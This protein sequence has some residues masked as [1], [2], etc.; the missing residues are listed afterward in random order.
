LYLLIID[1]QIVFLWLLTIVYV[2]YGELF[3]S[4]P[5]SSLGPFVGSTGCAH[6]DP[7]GR[8]R[9]IDQSET[10]GQ[11]RLGGENLGISWPKIARKTWQKTRDSRQQ[12]SVGKN[13]EH[14]N[15][16]EHVQNDSLAAKIWGNGLQGWEHTTYRLNYSTVDNHSYRVSTLVAGGLSEISFSYASFILDEAFWLHGCNAMGIGGWTTSEFA[17]VSSGSWLRWWAWC[18][19]LRPWQAYRKRRS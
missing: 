4:H 16:E 11:V 7:T 9:S 8:S 10:T 15:W 6:G 18:I 5:T 17:V 2:I 14:E 3:F 1:N 12:S 19:A 13:W